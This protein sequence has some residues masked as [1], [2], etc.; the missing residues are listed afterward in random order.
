MKKSS[1]KVPHGFLART[2]YHNTLPDPPLEPKFL[3]YQFDSNRY[4]EYKTNTLENQ[5]KIALH[6]PRNLGIHIDLINPKAYV[7][8]NKNSNKTEKQPLSKTLHPADEAL[9]E[10]EKS[11]ADI[12]RSQWHNKQ[13]NIFRR[14]EIVSAK[15]KHWGKLGGDIIERQVGVGQKMR[16]RRQ[17]QIKQKAMGHHMPDDAELPGG[18]TLAKKVNKMHD[19][20]ATE[21]KTR[22][23]QIEAIEKG[24]DAVKDT[25]GKY[26]KHHTKKDVYATEYLPIFPDFECWQHPCCQVV[27]HTD[28][29]QGLKDGLKDGNERK[30]TDE[31]LSQAMIRGMVDEDGDQFVG[32]F[33][34]TSG[35]LEKRNIDAQACVPYDEN[36]TYDYL[37]AKEYN[38]IVK[39]F[40]NSKSEQYFFFC[41]RNGQVFYNELD[42]KVRLT[43][44]KK[45]QEARIGGNKVLRPI[46]D[47]TKA[48][49]AVRHRQLNSDEVDNHHE[50]FKSLTNLDDDSDTDSSSDED[51]D[52]GAGLNTNR[53][54]ARSRSTIDQSNDDQTRFDEHTTLS[55]TSISRSKTMASSAVTEETSQ[56]SANHGDNRSEV[57]ETTMHVSRGDSDDDKSMA[58]TGVKGRIR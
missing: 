44:R 37:L 13:T 17:I 54:T 56:V 36:E 40:K 42:T 23:Q 31:E 5:H 39:N 38:W 2:I 27:F 34:P 53:S 25:T 18:R 26:D 58:A 50:R 30:A 48:V 9:C 22:E 55:N 11:K 41:W 16:E 10:D 1:Q 4:T 14:S 7:S 15:N 35:T 12:E 20:K 43:K 21:Y 29:A 52:T 49:L 32:Y 28:P 45:E 24:F 46:T 47:T 51:N 3:E 19:E 6:V 57:T 8:S 33:M